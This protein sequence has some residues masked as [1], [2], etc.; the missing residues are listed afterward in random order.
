MADERA[1][2]LE[3]IRPVGQVSVAGQA[4]AAPAPASA[5]AAET[6]VAAA[7]AESAT[8]APA[9]AA[10]PGATLY[11]AKGCAGCHGADAKSPIMPVYPKIAG[12]S[13]EYIDFQM[14]AIKDGSRANGQSVVMKGIMAGVSEADIA[15][16]A[17]YLGALPK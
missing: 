12:Q 17:E 13:M 5:P 7:P 6:T 3:R 10:S 8:P 16:L 2:V 4:A 9:A 15:A 1:E 11:V 14:K